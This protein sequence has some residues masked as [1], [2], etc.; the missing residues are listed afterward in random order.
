MYYLSHPTS[1]L[2]KID[3]QSNAYQLVAEF[4]EL[5]CPNDGL[6]GYRIDTG[7]KFLGLR[8]TLN[9]KSSALRPMFSSSFN[10]EEYR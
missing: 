9:G 6:F 2:Q 5:E 3:K 10:I 4:G 7:A 8:F 1:Y